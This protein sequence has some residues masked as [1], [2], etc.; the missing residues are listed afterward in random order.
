MKHLDVRVYV[1]PQESRGIFKRLYNCAAAALQRGDVNH[2]TGDVHY[3]ALFMCK[4]RTVLTIHDCRG[5][6][7]ERGV[8]RALYYWLWLKLPVA[9]SRLVTVISEKTKQDVLRY[10]SCTEKKLRV[11]PDPVGR[12]FAPAPKTFNSDRPI[13]LQVGGSWNKN[14]RRLVAA[15]SGL[16]CKLVIIGVLS[17]DDWREVTG[18]A[19]DIE[20]V[21]NLSDADVA[22]RYREADIVTFCSI[23]EGFG[24]PILEGNAVGRPVIT[25]NLEPM[26]SVAG[27]AACLVNP[28]EPA[29]IRAG[30]LRVMNNPQYREDLVRRGFENVKR[31]S[32][33][34][35]AS[36]YVSV[37]EE[38]T[39]GVERDTGKCERWS[40]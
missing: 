30:I 18:A 4:A 12:E 13:I 38:V 32:V 21:S 33:D 35:I 9:R 34:T 37:Y 8:R 14:I 22:Q 20:C 29:S 24:M 28:Y 31:F 3:L 36:A 1:C 27:G 5:M 6:S 11:I 15:V 25:S 7:C 40:L 17:Q 16:Q 26:A 23:Y 10:T 2:I 39:I 19:V